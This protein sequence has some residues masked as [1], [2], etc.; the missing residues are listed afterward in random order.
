MERQ[1]LQRSF[2]GAVSCEAHM[3]FCEPWRYSYNQGPHML[4]H[5]HSQLPIGLVAKP[6]CN[7][8]YCYLSKSTW[9]TLR[10]VRSSR[11]L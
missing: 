10:G 7:A 11:C 8:S 6:L 5:S 2:V 1:G 3:A 9:G 4:T